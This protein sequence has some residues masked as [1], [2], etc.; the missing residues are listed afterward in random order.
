MFPIDM[1]P[2]TGGEAGADGACGTARVACRRFEP[3]P[4]ATLNAR[5]FLPPFAWPPL[6][7][8]MQHD[9]SALPPRGLTRRAAVAVAL[10]APVLGKAA[11][12]RLRIGWTD[13]ADAEAITF[14]IKL[15]LERRLGY[16]VELV[17]QDVAALFESVAAGS[18]DLMPMCWLPNTH[19]GYWAAI[20]PRVTDLGVLYGGTRIGWIVPGYV[21]PGELN[22]IEDL[23]R[24]A[25]RQRLGGRVQG[26]EAGSG[27][28]RASRSAVEQYRLEGYQL[29]EGSDAAMAAAVDGALAGGRWIVAAAWTPHYLFSRHSL[30]YLR[31]PK[32]V[33]GGTEDVHVLGRAGFEVEHPK[34]AALLRRIHMPISDLE[35]LLLIS[36]MKVYLGQGAVSTAER[37]AGVWLDAHPR[38]VAAWL[39]R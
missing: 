31:D 13:W 29:A 39:G 23:L 18:I 22:T 16:Q 4:L 9:P 12:P 7:T 20:A 21:P 37:T 35:A 34:A 11:A 19:R 25:V 36:Q 10:S 33:F 26:I 1:R 3:G 38:L 8:P 2:R 17:K 32:G 24:P 5:H 6:E 30:R 15:L 28:M 14:V 27:L